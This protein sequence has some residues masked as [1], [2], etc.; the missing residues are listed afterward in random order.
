LKKGGAILKG[1]DCCLAAEEIGRRA[2]HELEAIP[3]GIVK[4]EHYAS[5]YFAS[6]VFLAS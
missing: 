3:I 4:G 5:V 2:F 1:A 6:E